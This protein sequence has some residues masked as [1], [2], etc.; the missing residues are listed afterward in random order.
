MQTLDQRS[1][2][3]NNLLNMGGKAKVWSWLSLTP[4]AIKALDVM[5]TRS[6]LGLVEARRVTATARRG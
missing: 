1:S 6:G 2:P 4:A 5:W 3:H